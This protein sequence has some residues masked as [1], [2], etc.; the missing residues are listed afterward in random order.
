MEQ[1]TYERAIERFFPYVSGIE[2]QAEIFKSYPVRV[3]KQQEIAYYEVGASN[4]TQNG[5]ITVAKN[6]RL[7]DHANKSAFEKLYLRPGDIIL[8]YRTK[9][10][11][12]GLFVEPSTHPLVPNPSLIIIRSG[13]VEQGKYL[14]ACLQQPFIKS[15]IESNIIHKVNHSAILDIDRFRL[16]VIPA[17][18]DK[19]MSELLKV[20]RYRHYSKRILRLQE[21]FEHLTTLLS[22]E[23]IS[24]EYQ[25]IDETYLE[26]IEE[27]IGKLESIISLLEVSST[28]SPAID[29]L[30]S[31]FDTYK[32]INL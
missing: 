29:L 21:K 20:D 17:A 32:E 19:T 30:R 25:G 31:D 28:H 5:E 16:L 22:S 3:R 11:L 13:S 12:M 8:P 18:T 15:Y 2:S 9:R 4:I 6:D 1:T 14:F 27:H 10:L 24:G 26:D 23:A 7:K